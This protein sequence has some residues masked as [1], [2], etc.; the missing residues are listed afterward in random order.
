MTQEEIAGISSLSVNTVKSVVRSIYTKLGAI[1][2]ADVVRI[3]ADMG[4][5]GE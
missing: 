5:V 4:L 3:A 2:K 1:N